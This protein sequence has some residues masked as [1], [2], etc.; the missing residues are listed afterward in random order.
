MARRSAE[1][2][3]VV[4]SLSKAVDVLMPTASFIEDTVPEV[5]AALAWV[6]CRLL[7]VI[8]GTP[9]PPPAAAAAGFDD[10]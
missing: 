9:P 8:V 7:H 5:R 6:L 1:V 2:V 4:E 3:A 10:E